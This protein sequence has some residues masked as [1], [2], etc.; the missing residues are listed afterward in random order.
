[1]TL[2]PEAELF[3]EVGFVSY[4]FHWSQ[5]DVLNMEHAMRRRWCQE[6]SNINSALT[7]QSSKPAKGK[8][9]SITEFGKKK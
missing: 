6:I 5:S 3:Q 8:E 1:M 7:A 4:Y 2:Y 9:V